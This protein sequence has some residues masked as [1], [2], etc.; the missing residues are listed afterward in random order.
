LWRNWDVWE[1]LCIVLWL[2][3]W[4]WKRESIGFSCSI[5]MF[6]F[7]YILRK[8]VFLYN[9]ALLCWVW[10]VKCFSFF[11]FY[12]RKWNK[13]REKERGRMVE[14]ERAAG[15]TKSY[16]WIKNKELRGV[17]IFY[18][19]SFIAIDFYSFSYKFAFHSCLFVTYLN[20]FLVQF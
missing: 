7:F 5:S 15:R 16:A 10:V 17:T 3:H 13:R 9:K 4:R 1:F 12:Y 14:R 11:L 20:F 6:G 19:F 18:L 2:S 8:K